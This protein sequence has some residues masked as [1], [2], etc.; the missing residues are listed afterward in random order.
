MSKNIFP[1]I[2]FFPCNLY[3]P[4]WRRIIIIFSCQTSHFDKLSSLEKCQY[5]LN[6]S[7]QFGEKRKSLLRPST[8]IS[9]LTRCWT[10]E[11]FVLDPRHYWPEVSPPPLTDIHTSSGNTPRLCPRTTILLQNTHPGT[12]VKKLN[13]CLSG[14]LLSHKKFVRFWLRNIYFCNSTCLTEKYF[15]EENKL[16]DVWRE[17]RDLTR[18]YHCMISYLSLPPYVRMWPTWLQF[19]GQN[20]PELLHL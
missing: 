11:K 15:H 8:T 12:T 2:S 18:S 17:M 6:S 3:W 1:S 4:L 9:S 19:G 20:W 7:F 10:K 5:N 16:E 13:K 14:E